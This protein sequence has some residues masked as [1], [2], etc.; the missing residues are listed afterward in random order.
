MHETPCA[1]SRA[2]LNATGW[3]PEEL[4]EV[5]SSLLQCSR[6][7]DTPEL[8]RELEVNEEGMSLEENREYIA[9]EFFV[10]QLFRNGTMGCTDESYIDIKE[11]TEEDL[12]VL[13]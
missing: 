10:M 2:M 1:A 11:D 3:R 9:A 5:L 8:T 4:E 6:T 12:C 7:T 13:E